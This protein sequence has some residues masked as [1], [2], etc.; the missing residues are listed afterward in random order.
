MFTGYHVKGW[1]LAGVAWIPVFEGPQWSKGGPGGQLAIGDG[2]GQG[3]H[4]APRSV[5]PLVEGG[6]RLG[7]MV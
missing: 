2:S 7:V 1:G 6:H 4:A 3:K 5:Q